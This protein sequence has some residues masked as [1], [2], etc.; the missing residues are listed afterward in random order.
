MPLL[1][2]LVKNKFAFVY[3][4]KTLKSVCPNLKKKTFVAKGGGEGLEKT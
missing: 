3:E 4:K 1:C 2:N